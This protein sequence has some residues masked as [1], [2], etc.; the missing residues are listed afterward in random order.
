MRA[1]TNFVR[2]FTIMVMLLTVSLISCSDDDDV[3]S[4]ENIVGTWDL[5]DVEVNG[6][7]HN[8]TSGVYS[9]YGAMI[10]F[11]SNG[12]YYGSGALGNGHGTWTKSGKTIT[13]YVDGNVYI[14]YKVSSY[15]DTAMQGTMKQGSTSMKFKAKKR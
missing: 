11:Y 9:S 10:R 1:K 6:I 4:D 7:W 13:T 2:V 3:I 14:Q 12:L 15:T 5:T 8:V